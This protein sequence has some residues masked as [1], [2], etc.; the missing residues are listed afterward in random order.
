M[1]DD[2]VLSATGCRTL[3]DCRGLEKVSVENIEIG[4]ICVNDQF[5]PKELRRFIQLTLMTNCTYAC[6]GSC[7]QTCS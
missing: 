6:H 3:T 5:Q 4:V 7:S 2:T 1:E